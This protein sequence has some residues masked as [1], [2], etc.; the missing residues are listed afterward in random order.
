MAL[1]IYDLVLLDDDP[2]KPEDP[3]FD[4]MFGIEFDPVLYN[5]GIKGDDDSGFLQISIGGFAIDLIL[6][7]ELQ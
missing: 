5:I 6:N 7:Y 4:V 3:K 2:E 1:L